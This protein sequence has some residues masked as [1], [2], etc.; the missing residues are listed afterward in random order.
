MALFNEL[1][2]PAIYTIESS[3]CGNDMGPY[4]NYHF[5]TTNLM[6]TGRDFCRTLMLYLPIQ[7]PKNIVSN[8]MTNINDLFMHYKVISDSNGG[9]NV[10]VE[11]MEIYFERI[12]K[13][14][15][16]GKEIQT[17]HI[18]KGMTAVLRQTAE[19]FTDGN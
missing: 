11:N 8:F 12:K 4:K 13:V 3:F 10:D 14:Q 1:K 16:N 18:K 15:A 9:D 2:C 5:S 19:I 7:V 6:Q 17:K